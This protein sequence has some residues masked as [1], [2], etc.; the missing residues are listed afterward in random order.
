MRNDY[1]IFFA[2]LLITFQ[3]FGQINFE[4][5]YFINNQGK[6]INCLIKNIGWK[7]NPSKIVYKLGKDSKEEL[8]ATIGMMKEFGIGNSVKFQKF[9]VNI[10]K[11][12]ERYSEMS[13]KKAP[14]F[15]K[16]EILLKVLLEGEANLYYYEGQ[17][18][19][20]FF[21]SVDGSEIEQLIYKKFKASRWK[22]GT[23]TTYRNQLF[24]DLKCSRLTADSFK[25][26]RYN[27]TSLL[28]ILT[29]Y[30][31]CKSSKIINYADKKKA[32]NFNINIKAGISLSSLKM[33]FN[34]ENIFTEDR[35]STDFDT[36]ALY[37]FGAEL[38]YIF[39]TNKNK[40]ALFIEP[41]IFQT[42]KAESSIFIERSSTSFNSNAF[43]SY[44]FIEIPI[45]LRHYFYLTDTN[46]SK[47]FINVAYVIPIDLKKSAIDYADANTGNTLGGIEVEINSRSNMIFGV[48]YSFNNKYSIELRTATSRNVLSNGIT[49][50]KGT[51]TTSVSLNLGY[52]LF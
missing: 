6:R 20:R 45:G 12:S 43:A 1:I 22:T 50:L 27:E 39:A 41:T 24:N 40:W 18:I 44:T 38:E 48:G 9:T 10:D 21:Y 15:I 19:Y 49:E 28:A 31:E 46:I 2:A 17:N 33:E 32:G 51:Y 14:E 47:L 34:S 16:E 23:N 13:E 5:G 3:T 42:Y 35:F 36:K 30:N 25:N 26:I 4:P 37:K 29:K 7:D 11:S 52:T 8:T